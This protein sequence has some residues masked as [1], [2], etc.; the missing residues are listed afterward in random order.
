V[1]AAAVPRVALAIAG[2]A[3][4]SRLYELVRHQL[5]LVLARA[6]VIRI[7]LVLTGKM[8]GVAACVAFLG[9]L[10]TKAGKIYLDSPFITL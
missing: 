6:L 1:L 2:A 10:V 4:C 9:I 5:P 8:Y 3:R 7:Y